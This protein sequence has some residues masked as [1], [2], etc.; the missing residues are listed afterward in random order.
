MR[1]EV[2]PRFPFLTFRQWS[3]AMTA[4]SRA[5]DTALIN[6]I[7]GIG[8]RC[9]V[10]A[11]LGAMCGCN[12]FQTGEP[13]SPT[14]ALIQYPSPS[15]TDNVLAILSLSVR[16]KDSRAFLDRLTADFRFLPDPVQIQGPDFRTFPVEW[17]TVQEEMALAVLF[18]NSDSVTVDWSSV[19]TQHRVEGASVGATYRVNVFSR[20][21]LTASY[22]GRV[23]I[24][25][26]QVAGSWAVREWRDYVV[27]GESNT[28]GLLRA[29]LLGSG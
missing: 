18:S 5:R 16:A 15:S 12:P 22:T 20:T 26:T 11:V 8:R 7:L 9:C 19:F 23:E 4:A 27:S 28:W 21:S 6:G 1:P 24:V 2:C 29:R 10:V 13:E 17:G 25:M 14:G 3:L